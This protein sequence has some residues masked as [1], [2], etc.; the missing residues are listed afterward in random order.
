MNGIK[1][2]RS[3]LGRARW[4]GGSASLLSASIAIGVII[5]AG[6][7]ALFAWLSSVEQPVLAFCIVAIATL[8]ISVTLGWALLVDRS[9]LRGA[10]DKPEESIESAWY[11]KAA[12]GAFGD[13][14]M[15]G[16]LGFAG[17][18]FLQLNASVSWILLAVTLLAMIDFGARYVWLRKSAS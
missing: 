14:V 4:G 9:S 6:A 13:I 8:P 3:K 16:A 12:S 2:T 5:S 17:F 1:T 10:V 7:G 15:V 18:G 11:E